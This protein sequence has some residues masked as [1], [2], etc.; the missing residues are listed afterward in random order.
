MITA[1]LL[2]RLASASLIALI[3]LGIAW[4]MWLAPF[5]IGGSIF[6]LK[7]VPLLFPL[8]GV[9]KKNIYT[10]QWASM[11]ILIYFTEGIVR[12]TGDAEAMS[13]YL[14]LAEIFLSLLFFLCAIFYVRPYKKIAKAKQKAALNARQ[15]Q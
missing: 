8:K 4:E 13:R 1:P 7:V 10:L 2:H 6:V 14:A 12:A 11:F 15:D 3:A 9:L 5:Q